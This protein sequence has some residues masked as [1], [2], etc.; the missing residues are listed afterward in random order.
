MK[1]LRLLCY[2]AIGFMLAACAGIASA[3][4]IAATVKP[5][6]T[7]TIN[8]S[9]TFDYKSSINE[10][11]QAKFTQYGVSQ[12]AC[13]PDL[14]PSGGGTWLYQQTVAYCRYNNTG[15]NCATMTSIPVTG[16]YSCPAGYQLATASTCTNT[17]TIYQC[18][19]G[20]N[21]TLSGTSCTRP[22]CV[23]PQVR[24]AT[25][26]VCQAP[27]ACPS[28]GT[29]VS[30]GQYQLDAGYSPTGC[31][32][33]GCLASFVGTWPTGKDSAG[34]L[35]GTGSMQYV[36]G[37][38]Q[39]SCV[40]GTGGAVAI[41]PAVT[42]TPAPAPT[43]APCAAGEGVLTSTSGTVA[44]V[45][46]GTPTAQT[47][48]VSTT[49]KVETFGD[50]STKTTETTKTTNPADGVTDTTVRT[51]I[52]AP[53]SGGTSGQAGTVGT[54]T[55]SE[56]TNKTDSGSTDK[57]DTCD[58]SKTACGSAGT[59]SESGTLYEPKYPDGLGGLLT[60]KYNDMKNTPIFGL[61]SQLAP[62][63]VGGAGQCPAWSFNGS[64]NARMSLGSFSLAPPCWV[65]DAVRVILLV[66]ALLTA[67]RLIFGG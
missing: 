21:W 33:N 45:P 53:S 27:P 12:G 7:S 14:S 1:V 34:K 46:A 26:G 19:S 24:N 35:Y 50:G 60:T 32:P 43:K 16:T 28:A 49:K 10:A 13:T 65:W 6:G 11:C 40:P 2:F 29:E 25:T 4:T 63:N 51:T 23:A 18:P 48:A 54:G 17:T 59:F 5:A 22:D 15:T 57:D 58:P 66:T 42:P 20:Q 31:T 9:Q 36:G 47:P 62:T 3:E 38:S 41:K 52:G 8:A 44:C 55:T 64:I 30:S 67:R 37:D 61:V 56:S 39:G